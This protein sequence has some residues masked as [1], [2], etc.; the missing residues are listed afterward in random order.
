MSV[1]LNLT[2][3]NLAPENNVVLKLALSRFVFFKN[4]ACILV[5]SKLAPAK[6]VSVN[7]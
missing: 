5:P 2:P 1:F 4:E 7:F 3:V 6:F